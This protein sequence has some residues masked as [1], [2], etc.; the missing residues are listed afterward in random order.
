MKRVLVCAAASVFAWS[1]AVH[2]QFMVELPEPGPRT[3]DVPL[4]AGA[5]RERDAGLTLARRAEWKAAIDALTKA[6]KRAHCTPSLMYNLGLAH[7]KAGNR[8]AAALWYKAYLAAEP[9]A[10]NGPTLRDEIVRI[11]DETDAAARRTFDE[12]ERLADALSATPTQTGARSLRQQA[13]E[14]IANS[15]YAAGDVSRGDRLLERI[16]ALPNAIPITEPDRLNELRS[17]RGLFPAMFGGDLKRATQILGYSDI[18]IPAY[19]KA[20][21]MARLYVRRGDAKRARE[22]IE[23]LDFD[24]LNHIPHFYN[25]ESELFRL[26][27]SEA[28]GL[29][30]TIHTRLMKGEQ[31]Q[32]SPE[33]FAHVV[34]AIDAALM[35]GDQKIARDLAKVARSYYERF[36][37]DGANANAGSALHYVLVLAVLGDADAIARY[38]KLHIFQLGHFWTTEALFSRI[39]LAAAFTMSRN[40]M[41]ATIDLLA[42]QWDDKNLLGQLIEK[43]FPAAY[44]ARYVV[45]GRK[46][47]ALSVLLAGQ[48]K[49]KPNSFRIE[50]E[51]KRALAFAVASRDV[52]LALALVP[53]VTKSDAVLHYL[54]RLRALIGNNADLNRE[55]TKQEL[56]VCQ[57]WRPFDQEHAREARWRIE[58]ARWL[59]PADFREVPEDLETAA[60]NKP[61]TLPELLA[62]HATVLTMGASLVWSDLDQIR[63]TLRYTYQGKEVELPPS[64]VFDLT[65]RIDKAYPAFQ[66]IENTRYPTL[67]I[68]LTKEGQQHLKQFSTRNI[69]Q[70]C[71]LLFKAKLVNVATIQSEISGH[72]G[73]H[74]L[75]ED[76]AKSLAAELTP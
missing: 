44:F 57:G 38:F 28:I 48:Q 1:T 17:R 14:K 23:P 9:D 61:E 65:G 47:K 36:D 12:A 54:Y 37:K 30:A 71:G 5:A 59:D 68:K 29:L 13:Y 11:G 4:E 56:T 25:F 41:I 72:L 74:G 45:E 33:Y 73:I 3:A 31:N 34:R 69:G 43:E 15:A 24:G 42:R 67:Q 16:K 53:H 19:T 21:Y 40:D 75:S 10:Q 62:S 6:H 39:A 27:G 63:V 49:D 66:V 60:R 76:E 52:H 18:R 2:A 58:Q 22:W 8:V 7:A 51:Y 26:R 35:D 50:D 46:E 32:F 64:Q 20:G 55:I 70:Q